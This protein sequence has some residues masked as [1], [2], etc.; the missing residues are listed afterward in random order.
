MLLV[1]CGGGE[2]SLDTPEGVA[3]AALRA[4][5]GS[6]ADGFLALAHNPNQAVL[7]ETGAAP[8]AGSYAAVLRDEGQAVL[9]AELETAAHGPLPTGALHV[10]SAPDHPRDGGLDGGRAACGAHQRRGAVTDSSNGIAR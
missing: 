3:I 1:A 6:D 8:V 4:A 5:R 7:D 10:W 2:P 9:R